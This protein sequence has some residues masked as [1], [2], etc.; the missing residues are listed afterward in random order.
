MQARIP[1]STYRLQFNRE[2]TFEQARALADYFAELG[3]TDYYSSPVLQARPGSPHG[4]D[5]VEH[6]RVNPE[7]G[8]EEQL[9]ALLQTLR[10]RGMGFLVDVVPNHMSIVTAENRWWQDVLEN[11]Q[12]SP[13]ARYFDIDW[14]PPNPTLKGRVLLPILGDQFGRVLERGE[15]RV[16][17]RDG[18]F[19]LNYWETQLPVAARSSTLV[20]RLALESAR[21]TLGE[22]DP[23][24]LELESILSALENLPPRTETPRASTCW[25]S[26]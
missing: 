5:I 20:L 10:G 7:A 19:L 8:G 17:Y 11:G 21:A 18:G 12:S 23:N 24:I 26:C 3:V 13:H 1:V 22:S 2:F 16:S 14:N 4:Y 25:K 15:L 6:A 9:D